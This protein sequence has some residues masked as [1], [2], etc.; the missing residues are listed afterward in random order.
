MVLS[1]A[2]NT[3]AE[4]IS[5]RVGI[6]KEEIFGRAL[7]LLEEQLTGTTEI[8]RTPEEI[9]SVAKNLSEDSGSFSMQEIIDA[10]FPGEIIF[11]N[12]KTKIQ[13]G[14]VLVIAGYVRKQVWKSNG[15][16]PRLWTKAVS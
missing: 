16:R 3:R 8:P 1:E 14:N 9:L 4:Q 11:G 15:S 12:H 2:L 13:I 10:L 5:L 7:C 6:S